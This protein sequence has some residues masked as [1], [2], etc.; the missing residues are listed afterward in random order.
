MKFRKVRKGYYVRV[1]QV[2]DHGLMG[3][4]IFFALLFAGVAYIWF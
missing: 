1:P 3:D 4:T 2:P